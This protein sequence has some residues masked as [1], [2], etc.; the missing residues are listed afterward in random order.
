M[1]DGCSLSYN[2]GIGF[3]FCLAFWLS[4]FVALQKLAHAIYREFFHKQKLKIFQL[5]KKRSIQFFLFLLT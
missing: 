3:T 2:P 1:H 4:H 5:K